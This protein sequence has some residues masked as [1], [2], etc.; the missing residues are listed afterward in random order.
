MSHTEGDAIAAECIAELAAH[1]VS[2]D[3]IE[4]PAS[5]TTACLLGYGWWAGVVR[6]ADAIRLLY[7]TGLAPE[8]STLVRTVLLHA[9][10]LEWLVRDPD[11]V[12]SAVTYE[13]TYRRFRLYEQARRRQWPL[14]E[15]EDIPDQPIGPKPRD[16]HLLR[17]PEK[18]CERVEML[19][20][21]IPFMIESAYAHPSAIGGDRYLHEENGVAMIRHT[22]ASAPVGLAATAIYVAVATDAFGRLAT[23]PALSAM[24]INIGNKLG[25]DRLNP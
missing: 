4:V 13:H 10:S 9:A 18:L 19:S 5:R 7:E 12:L 3:S 24:A 22:P 11:V 8:A 2:I 6:T 14:G 20:S 21:Y 23:I 1:L 17:N 15:V 16:L 25:I